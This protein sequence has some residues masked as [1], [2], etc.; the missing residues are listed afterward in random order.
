MSRCQQLPRRFEV[1]WVTRI[2]LNDCPAC[3]LMSQRDDTKQ[4]V[5]PSSGSVGQRVLRALRGGRRMPG[6]GGSAG[7]PTPA[8]GDCLRNAE[9]VAEVDRLQP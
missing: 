9:L 4:S 2:A 7:L 5:E 3:G 8:S 6:L 1:R